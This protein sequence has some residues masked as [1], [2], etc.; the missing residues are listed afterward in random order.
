VDP[1]FRGALVREQDDTRVT[2]IF[3]TLIEWVLHASVIAHS[4]VIFLLTQNGNP[5]DLNGIAECMTPEQL[6][7]EVNWLTILA[8]V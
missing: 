5:N 2:S 1:F 3:F 4:V 8:A 7:P 6:G